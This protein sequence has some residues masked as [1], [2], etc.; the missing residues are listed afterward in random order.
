MD[1]NSLYTDLYTNRAT[2]AKNEK[3]SK[4]VSG[5]DY[6]KASDEEL[7]EVC[8]SFE[9]YFVEQVLKQAMDVF[10]TGEEVSSGSMS[11]LQEYYKSN[12]IQEYASTITERQDM[13]IAKTLYEQ[14]K[15]N[16]S[17]DSIKDASQLTEQKEENQPENQKVNDASAIEAAST[18]LA[19]NEE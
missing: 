5:K 4:S 3:L 18:V 19:S 9:S 16:Y 8:K 10:T 6:S 12:L 2:D 11:T 1:I 17:T 15:R 7:M 14:M 13:G